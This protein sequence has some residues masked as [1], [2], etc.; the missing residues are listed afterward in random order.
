MK[1]NNYKV[2]IE[3][4]IVFIVV[5]GISVF[6]A[7]YSSL[8]ITKNQEITNKIMAVD[9]PSI[10][11]LENMNLLVTRS[12]MYTTNWV[13]LQSNKED[14]E[15]LKKLHSTEYP[16]LKEKIS[17]LMTSW[18]DKESAESITVAFRNFE[19]LMSYQKAI[20]EKLVRFDDYEDPMKK[21]GAEEIIESQILPRTT[22]IVSQLNKV[23]INKK[24]QA[25]VLHSVMSASYRSLMWS[26]LGIAIIV[27][28]VILLAAFY[29]SNNIIVPLM[30]LKNHIIRMGKGEI[31]E[32]A[33]SFKKN[34]VGLMTEAIGTLAESLRRTAGFA[35]D[36]GKG[37]F[38]VEFQP[39]SPNDELGNALIQMRESL[40]NA[41]TENRQR[42]WIATGLDQLSKVL[43]ENT[44]DIEKLSD[45]II[46]S[47][48]KF[49]NVCNG[50]IYLIE[51]NRY[52]NQPYI[53]LRGSY[54]LNENQKLKRR[55]KMGEGLVG[56]SIKDSETIH[57]KNAPVD[58]LKIESCLGSATASYILIVPLKHHGEIYGA[59]E[60]ASFAEFNEHD[61]KFIESIGE[62]MGS[63]IASSKANT[64]T[65][66][67]LDE[68]TKQAERLSAQE[69]ELR[70]TNDELSHQSLLL[71]ASEDG[72]RQSN[73]E[74]KEKAALVE[75][76]N[77]R[78]EQARHALSIKVKELELNS[79][80]KSEFL[81]NMSH[82][83]RTPLNS[84]LI[85]AKLLSDNKN[86]TL[87]E[88][89]IEYAKVIYKSGNDLVTLINDVLDLSKIEA[90]KLELL[91]TK[92][93]VKLIKDD[94]RSLF[95]EVASQKKI[96]FSIE[97]H[98]NIPEYITTD[99]L[100]LEQII[101][102]L[103]SNA[104]KFTDAGG[105]ITMKIKFPD[106]N[107][108]FK[109]PNLLKSKQVIEFSVTDSGIGIPEDKQQL[110]F[111]A[112]QQEDG[113][114]SRK[115]GGTGLGLSISRMLVALLGGEMQLV[116]E[117]GKGS[118]F[119]IFLPI[120]GIQNTNESNDSQKNLPRFERT[121][122][123]SEKKQT[124]DSFHTKSEVADD[125]DTI[126]ENDKV[127]LIVED[128]LNFAK[129]LVDFAHEKKYKAVVATQGDQGIKYAEK[130]K[131]SA[132]ILD[133]QLPIMDG[134][135]V[136]KK[137]KENKTLSPIPVHVMTA[138]DRKELGMQMG[139]T[140]YLRKPF[141]N[142]DLDNAFKNI[143]HSITTNIKKI[144]IVENSQVQFDILKNLIQNKEKG[145]QFYS[146][147]N[148]GK[149]IELLETEQFDCI[150]LNLDLE[151]NINKRIELLEQF[152]K[153]EKSKLVPVVVYTEK[154]INEDE[155]IQFNELTASVIN[156]ND[157]TSNRLL[158]EV[159]MFLHKAEQQTSESN[160][161]ISQ[162]MSDLLRGKNI[163]IV[164][165][166][167][168]N[169]YALTSVLEGQG[170]NVVA[171]SDGNDAILKIEKNKPF[172]II[173]M[174]IMMPVMDGYTAIKEIRKLNQ[175]KKIPIIAQTA[176]AM[177]GDR[178]KCI[179]TGASDYITKPINVEQLLSVLRI[180][181]YKS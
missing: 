132:I 135:T 125:S 101:K 43:R 130:I 143:E 17:T 5:I 7:I 49:L 69:E 94:M 172:D 89:E 52:N 95:A 42:H 176:K 165:D 107:I 166:D 88:K 175:Y 73:N 11:A 126:T 134:W 113:S 47:L 26:V 15:F 163:L 6:N 60:L 85:L 51:T 105:C 157:E 152:R 154:E 16:E 127:L 40:S 162:K 29:L 164:D 57:L 68:T 149:A 62:T 96:D 19:S 168:R 118:T 58:Y 92:E 72:L 20:M 112:F 76:Q 63:T 13:Y 37:N 139:A 61:I 121:T 147:T 22:Q 77:E 133:M 28:I 4:Y 33:V 71:Q 106:R 138:M 148:P 27:V 173:L 66:K 54:A 23:I 178:E 153:N 18:Q 120:E 83:L 84:V 35:K 32:V 8:N 91:M 124:V 181:L 12:K 180:W 45:E 141:D 64:L 111:E 144:L 46:N 136:L 140:T 3:I 100:R 159:E 160:N 90:G 109:N 99:K 80:Y 56:Q 167:M 104:F 70:Q 2:D 171:A 179:Q 151:T 108:K 1:N 161:I 117:K 75:E 150:I 24:N 129:I 21:F 74:L 155:K 9:I 14:K 102:N 78:L 177:H 38:K 93:E 25:D 170:M 116:S 87:T 31:P 137:L 145:S 128:D 65:K 119:F 55:I 158:Q 67:L 53:H 81:A 10:Q 79:K 142:R 36:I 169:I 97:Q 30:K 131:P 50:A 59:I 174:D 122:S 98:S 41:D 48:V 82:E 115:Y 156:K 86:K 39:L 110:I 123:E 146:A 34:A 114:T 44:D 103:L